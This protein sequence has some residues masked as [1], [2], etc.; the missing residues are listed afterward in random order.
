MPKTASN[1]TILTT[2]KEKLDVRMDQ[3]GFK[4]SYPLTLISLVFVVTGLSFRF[5]GG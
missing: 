3:F 2:T 4:I 5:G 1:Y